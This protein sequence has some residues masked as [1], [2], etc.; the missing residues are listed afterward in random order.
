MVRL[1]VLLDPENLSSTQVEIYLD[2]YQ[3]EYIVFNSLSFFHKKA[4]LLSVKEF[5][6]EMAGKI[7]FTC[8]CFYHINSRISSLARFNFFAF[9]FIQFFRLGAI[10]QASAARVHI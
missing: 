5:F 4:F 9:S 2:K 1:I 6:F 10:C 3:L 7:A 8:A